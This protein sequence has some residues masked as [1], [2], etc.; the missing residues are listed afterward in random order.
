MFVFLGKPTMHRQN[1]GREDYRHNRK[2]TNRYCTVR[3]LHVHV[4][5]HI[6]CTGIFVGPNF[7]G[8]VTPTKIKPMKICYDEKLY[9]T[10]GN[11]TV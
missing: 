8:K 5:I 9:V 11:Y 2:I 6:V 7:C 3:E 10:T 1:T 4:F